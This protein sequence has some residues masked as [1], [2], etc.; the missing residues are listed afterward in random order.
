MKKG[1]L[2]GLLILALLPAAGAQ[3]KVAILSSD[4][5]ADKAVAEVWA[6]KIDATTVFTPWGTLSKEAVDEIVFSGATI[7]YV[8]GGL[9]AIP[10]AEDRLGGYDMT[11]IQIGGA[12]REETSLRVAN[13]LS[14]TR[15]VVLDGYDLPSLERAVTLGAAEGI[16]IVYFHSS[17]SDAGTTLRRSGVNSVT[18]ISNPSFDSV[19]GSIKAAGIEV[20]EPQVNER[21][22]ALKVL[23]E[24]SA[25]IN[26][27]APIVRS[28]KD[29]ST[30]A[31]AK[32][33]IESKISLSKAEDALEGNNYEEAFVQ[34]VDA[35]EKAR[36]AIALYNGIIA[37][38]IRDYV[39]AADN[40]ISNSDLAGAR[41][42]LQ[43]LGSPYGIGIPVPLIRDL[44]QYM[45]DITG[46][47]KSAVGKG[48]YYEMGAKYTKTISGKLIPGLSVDVELYQRTDETDAIDW[49]EQVQ[50]TPGFVSTD[51]HLKSFDGYPANFKNRTFPSTDKQNQEIF[52]KVAVGNIGVFT[53]FT[54]SVG[55]YESL[56]P[57]DDAIAMV[58][59]ITKEIIDAITSYE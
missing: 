48:T 53:R 12:N 41:E 4:N 57:Q 29:G 6:Q 13:Q 56:T 33:I 24:A 32:L 2:I 50:F 17:D 27:T 44:S 45:V 14:A 54:E 42:A 19:A 25:R 52:L 10:D 39:L 59:G 23:D 43:S 58:E 49:V 37:G 46:Y 21:T 1:I 38:G 18:L 35:E 15:M 20:V 55:T 47:R 5:P 11:V 16:P 8:V 30:L 26:A 7:V 3:G 22:S 34:A 9:V 31:A 51:W 36:Y 28:I 40:D